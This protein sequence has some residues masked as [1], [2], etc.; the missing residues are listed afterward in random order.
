MQPEPDES[1]GQGR[2]RRA[3]QREKRKM[4]IKLFVGGLNYSTD[5][6]SLFFNGGTA[7]SNSFEDINAVHLLPGGLVVLSGERFDGCGYPHGLAGCEIPVE[8]RI[9]AV[10]DVF[11]ALLSE[12]SYRSARSVEEA[13]AVMKAERGRQFDPEMIDALLGNLD[14]FLAVRG[15]PA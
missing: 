3:S 8:G 7:F 6:A 2:K 12:R 10:A 15:R 14:R 13:V 4:S 11:D 5:T 9:M 1:R